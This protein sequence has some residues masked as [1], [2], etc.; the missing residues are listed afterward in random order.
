MSLLSSH[1]KSVAGPAVGGAIAGIIC[2]VLVILVI[3]ICKRRSRRQQAAL[4]ITQYNAEPPGPLSR[5]SSPPMKESASDPFTSAPTLRQ[6]LPPVPNEA[7]AAPASH[8]NASHG[9]DSPLQELTR[10]LPMP[11]TSASAADRRASALEELMRLNVPPALIVQ[12]LDSIGDD[13]TDTP[14]PSTFPHPTAI[15][16]LPR[17]AVLPAPPSYDFKG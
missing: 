4:E 6:L 1:H 13:G 5:Q 10:A 7:A 11:V 8:P 14:G 16:S 17:G 12:V 9:T 2:V 3:L 15:Q